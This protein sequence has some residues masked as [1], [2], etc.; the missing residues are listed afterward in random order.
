VRFELV[1]EPTNLEHFNVLWPLCVESLTIARSLGVEPIMNASMAVLAHCGPVDLEVHDI[2]LSCAGKHFGPMSERSQQVGIDTQVQPWGVLELHRG[3]VKVEFD[4]AE[5]WMQ[6]LSGLTDVVVVRGTPVTVVCRED[7]ATLYR[8]GVE[9]YAGR[10]G[11]EIELR[12][13]DLE[14][15]LRLVEAAL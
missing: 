14:R 1:R 9:A 11:Q 15:K 8:R 4:E 2:D 7:L 5:R 6:G 13:A 3:N 10:S 12:H